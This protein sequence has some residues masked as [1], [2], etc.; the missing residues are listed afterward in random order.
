[1]SKYTLHVTSETFEREVLQSAE[2]V[3][4]DFWAPWCG[5]CRQIGPILDELATTHA[6]KVKVAKINVDDEPALATAFQVRGI[7]ALYVVESGQV[8]GQMV[9]F[10]GKARLV[11][12]FDELAAKADTAAA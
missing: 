10:G 1:M 5:P 7:P 6:G 8:T 2:P 12:L 9:G 11:S 3:V 4:I